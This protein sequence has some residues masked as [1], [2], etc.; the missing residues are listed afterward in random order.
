MWNSWLIL[1]NECLKY[2]TYSLGAFAIWE[3]KCLILKSEMSGIVLDTESP[4]AVQL[5]YGCSIDRTGAEVTTPFS[6]GLEE[7]ATST[8]K[9]QSVHWSCSSEFAQY[10]VGLWG[11]KITGRKKK[12][13]RQVKRRSQAEKWK[14]QA[15]E[16][17]VEGKSRLDGTLGWVIWD[18]L[19]PSLEYLQWGL[20]GHFLGELFSV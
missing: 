12:N 11:M 13:H 5:L 10:Q 18:P 16:Q 6:M 17:R 8:R 4:V 20:F 2:F 15:E 9:N 1:T 19:N 14:S 3:E 7:P